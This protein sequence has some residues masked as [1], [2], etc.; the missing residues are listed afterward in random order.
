MQT[1]AGDVLNLFNVKN[2]KG[3]EAIKLISNRDLPWP[4]K[5]SID[6]LLKEQE[7][8]DIVELDLETT[9]L[10]AFK[11]RPLAIQVG[12][13]KTAYVVD[14]DGLDLSV[15][16]FLERKHCLGH[17]IKFDLLFLLHHAGIFIQKVY[18]T[19]IAELLLTNGRIVARDLGSVVHRYLGVSL[20]KSS[21]DTIH[22]LGLR[23]EQMIKYSGN[24]VLYLKQVARKQTKRIR[25]EGL[26]QVCKDEMAVLPAFAYMEYSGFTL[27]VNK[28]KDT[29]RV[30][31]EASDQYRQKLEELITDRAPQLK[32][33]QYNLFDNG[34]IT[35]INWSA[36]IQVKQA[37]IEAG[38]MGEEGQMVKPELKK[39]DDPII[40]TYIDYKES[41]KR[42]G[43]YG[44]KFLRHVESDGKVHTKIK[45]LVKTGRTSCTP[46]LQNIPKREEFRSCFIPREGNKLIVCDYSGQESVILADMSQD[47]KLLEFYQSGEADLHS[48]VARL[49]WPDELGD[50][51]LS[52]IKE[53]WPGKRQIAKSANFAIVYGGNGNT[54]ANNLN[55]SVK[56]GERIYKGF[57]SAFGGVRDH[58]EGKY[59]ETIE[60]GC[61]LI[62]KISG[63]KLYFDFWDRF[64]HLH[65]I[66]NSPGFWTEFRHEKRNDTS[67]YKRELL[68]MKERYYKWEH[69]VRKAAMNAPIQGTAADQKKKAL[70]S[71]M[72]WIIKEGLF[73][74][75]HIPIEVHDEI[76]AECPVEIADNVA[77]ALQRC[78]EEA[79][80]HY[81]QTL[82][83]KADPVVLDCWWEEKN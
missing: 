28:W 65:N 4:H 47:E 13:G 18:D 19:Y 31:F 27:D 80:N 32:T 83:I 59:E 1:V 16:K 30:A 60:M 76:V 24:D 61:L 57:M 63:R 75:V 8:Y 37:F 51:S 62:N 15:F 56:E 14:V 21:Q 40:E 35:D 52:E 54:I 69:V 44:S 42:Q 17:N 53:Q 36:P 11:N 70:N 67:Y 78:M 5:A 49:I 82:K 6:E 48:F 64:I 74:V 81:L 39:I 66:V 41:M 38:V 50:L 71:F 77:I 26:T 7:K 9:G 73:G 55:I 20:D 79:G 10:N 34:P 29:Y 58:F 2:A 33:I 3:M 46:N 22:L 25:R 12:L 72:A 68:P 23:T 43:T 45:Q